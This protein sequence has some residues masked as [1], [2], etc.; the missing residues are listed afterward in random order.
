MWVNEASRLLT[1]NTLLEMTIQKSIVDV[2]VMYGPS[3]K[4]SKLED[5]ADRGGFNDRRKGL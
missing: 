1:E 3:S 4:S 2:E 5:N